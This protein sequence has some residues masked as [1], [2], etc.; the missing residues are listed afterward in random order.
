MTIAGA[1]I[2]AGNDWMKMDEY[3]LSNPWMYFGDP[4]NKYIYI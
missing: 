4:A 1:S 3:L 2:G